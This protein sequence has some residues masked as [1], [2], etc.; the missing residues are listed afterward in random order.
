MVAGYLASTF[1]WSRFSE[2]WD[3][4]L[5]KSSIPIDRQWGIRL[6]HRNQLQHFHGSFSG[7]NEVRRDEFL[8]KAGAIIRRHTRMPIGNAVVRKHFEAIVPKRLQHS[9]GGCYG[10]CAY[11]C[12]H[13]VK[14]YCDKYNQNDPIKY[15]FEAGAPGQGQV[16]R[17][18]DHL[19]KDER[20]RK[21]F[22][23]G[24]T[25]FVG[26][27]VRQLQAADCLVYDLGRYALDYELGRTRVPVINYLYELLGP[28]VPKDGQVVFWNEEALA[29][30]AKILADQGLFND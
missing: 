3:K 27:D 24:D 1:Q 30:H 16:K 5:R 7:W 2:Q 15:V 28:K 25:S 10:W 23:L 8:V 14:A 22:R 4:L 29:K 20:L 13:S 21:Y 12:L 11:S 9:I 18:F 17:L 6:V 26:K 19:Y